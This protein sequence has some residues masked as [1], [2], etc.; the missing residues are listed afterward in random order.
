M[1]VITGALGFIGSALIRKLNDEGHGW[2]LV[3]VDDFY[4]DYKEPN[5]DKKLVREW[6]HRDI[7][8]EIFAKMTSQIDFVFHL[9]AR[10][11]TSE[12]NQDI[13]QRLNLDYSKE[14]WNICTQ[15]QIPMV[16]AS[17]AA[18]YG[19][20]KLGYTD[21]HKLPTKAKPLNPYA[22][23]KNEFD[24]WALKQK[25]QPPHWAGLKFF[26]VYGPNEYHKGR[27]ASVVYHASQQIK[28]EGKVK[29]F[30]SH[31]KGIAD[32]DQKRDFIYIKDV[33]DICYHFFKQRPANG[34]YNVGTGTARSFKDLVMA[35]F[36]ALDQPADIEYID[37]PKDIRGTYQYF[38]EA[39]MAKLREAGYE[40][41]LYSLED[42]VK[43]YVENYLKGKIVW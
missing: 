3:V 25:E 37:T 16:Y 40:K 2:D 38:T 32:G 34:L 8:L 19:D 27:M 11:D 10:T 23:S 43:D 13:F 14:I 35:T 41:E 6:I 29:L 21:D 24:K 30:R 17:S 7:F 18:T 22:V 1:I 15:Y 39:N 42:G 12:Q 9:G 5:L 4:K 36:A 26:N 33:V 31:K 28:K 20:G